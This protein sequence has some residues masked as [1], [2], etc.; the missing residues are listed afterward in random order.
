MSSNANRKVQKDPPRTLAPAYRVGE[1]LVGRVGEGSGRQFRISLHATEGNQ[2]RTSA[3]S[4]ALSELALCRSSP[5]HLPTS[6]ACH[7]QDFISLTS[8][9]HCPLAHKHLQDAARGHDVGGG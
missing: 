5:A 1:E 3:R 2:Y 6:F 4:S 9:S 7:H 8:F